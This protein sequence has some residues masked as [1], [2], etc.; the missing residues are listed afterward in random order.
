MSKSQVGSMRLLDYELRM[1][2]NLSKYCCLLDINFL[3][4][5]L[6]C[7]AG[8]SGSIPESSGQHP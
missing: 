7:I 4:W 6:V 8:F 2:N 1:E 5:S 3:G